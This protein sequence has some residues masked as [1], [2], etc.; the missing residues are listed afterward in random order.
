MAKL[1]TI[2]ES[3]PRVPHGRSMCFVYAYWGGDLDAFDE[4]TQLIINYFMRK[5]S[6]SGSNGGFHTSS[7]RLWSLF[8]F[9]YK[10]LDIKYILHFNSKKSTL[11]NS[12]LFLYTL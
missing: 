11:K 3:L 2:Y 7:N 10:E 6:I 12:K 1:L 8:Y 9:L 4:R 5:C